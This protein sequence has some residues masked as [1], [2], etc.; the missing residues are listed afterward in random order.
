MAVR[1]RET[2]P[3]RT[4]D[5][6]GNFLPIDSKHDYCRRCRNYEKRAMARTPTWRRHRE[7]VLSRWHGLLIAAAPKNEF[8]HPRVLDA[9][10]NVIPMRKR[11]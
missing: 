3:C 9:S 11:A 7:A 5:D 8:K 4:G 10:S 6:C 2:K 1:Q